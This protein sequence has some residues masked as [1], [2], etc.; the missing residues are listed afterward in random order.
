MDRKEILEKLQSTNKNLRLPSGMDFNIHDK[1][2]T[3][4]ME[5]KGLMNNMQTDASAFEGWAICLKA[6]LP[7]YITEVIIAGDVLSFPKGEKTTTEEMHYNRFLYR[8]LKFTETYDWT[9]TN[10]YAD[11]IKQFK[12]CQLV[13]NV[14]NKD[15]E[16]GAS[17]KESKL[18]RAYCVKNKTFYNTIDHQLPVRLFKK[19]VKISNALTPGGFIDIWSIKE[20]V[21]NIYELKIRS[22]THV[23]IISELMYYLNVVTDI[24]T[25]KISIP[26]STQFRSQDKFFDLYQKKSCKKI[27]AY[28]LTDILHPMIEKKKEVVLKILNDGKFPIRICY[29][30]KKVCEYNCLETEK[31]CNLVNTSFFEKAKVNGPMNIKNKK[32]SHT[33]YPDYVLDPVNSDTNLFSSIRCSSK[34]YFKNNNIAWWRENE[35]KYFP[36]GHLL[37][38]QI[39]CLNHLFALRKD[40]EALLTI[41]N[42]ATKIDFDEVLPSLID[43]DGYLSFEF[44]Y[45]NDELLGEKDK[46]WRRGVLCTSIDVMIRVRKG[47]DNWLIPIEWKYTETYEKED[48]TCSK[49]LNRYEDLIKRSD[50]LTIPKN[51]IPHSI[52]FQEPSYELMRQTLLTE[53]LIRKG[54]AKN[55]FHLIVIPKGNID[56]REAVEKGYIPMLKV[57]S[58]FHIIDPQDLLDPL[59]GNANYSDLINYL[60]TRYW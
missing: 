44:A 47:S 52:Y 48:K 42:H 29:Y 1:V 26:M 15:A 55:F 24:M 11:A 43:D 3:I 34:E 18:E 25:S 60:E 2:L 21:L 9:K 8:L 33:Y 39:H 51:G 27:N 17:H 40:K 36:T 22:H 45:H 49:R 20:D 6:W 7:E 38:S 50:I 59:R 41:V 58:K 19:E 30:H 28:L 31:H 4:K 57:S 32:Y 16:E 12:D 54:L 46:G 5:E 10:D 53:Q 37:S 23:G 14:P 13:V 56:L 35:D